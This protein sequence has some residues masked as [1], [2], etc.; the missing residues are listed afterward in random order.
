MQRCSGEALQRNCYRGRNKPLI[1]ISLAPESDDAELFGVR[2]GDYQSDI[3]IRGSKITGTLMNYT[4]GEELDWDPGTWGAEER[5]GSFIA[6]KAMD[7]PENAEV[8][9]EVVGGTHGPVTL[10]SDLNIIVHITNK[11]TQKIKMTSSLGDFTYEK[12]Y[13]LKQIDLVT[14]EPEET[15]EDPGNGEG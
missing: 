13:D 10:D 2:V 8:Q 15:T 12:V 9:I 6:L 5:I 3:A 4:T 1:S 11:D 14:V 7:V